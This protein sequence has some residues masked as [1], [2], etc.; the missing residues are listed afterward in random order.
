M[1]FVSKYIS[2]ILLL[3]CAVSAEAQSFSSARSQ[4]TVQ[5]IGAAAP[6]FEYSNSM[7]DQKVS[8]HAIKPVSKQQNGNFSATRGISLQPVGAHTVS[9]APVLNRPGK[10]TS[11]N[12][13]GKT[14]L[15]L[16]QKKGIDGSS[17]GLFTED[18][19]TDNGLDRGQGDYRPG[20]LTP[21]G[22]ALIPMLIL[23]LCYCLFL[24]VR[25]EARE[26]REEMA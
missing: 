1:K 22:D 25:G 9:Y 6:S 5:T 20:E 12:I 14:D 24:L 21:L 4:K 26:D 17:L 15:T 18:F 19:L 10:V 13:F 23:L 11:S 7:L 3:L 2:L 8:V 16:E